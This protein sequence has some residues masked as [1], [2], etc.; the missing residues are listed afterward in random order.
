MYRKPTHIVCY[1]KSNSYNPKSI[2][3]TVFNN[4]VDRL[5]GTPSKQTEYTEEYKH[6]L[7]TAEINVSDK[8]IIRQDE[9]H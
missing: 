1:I 4:L 6:V 7:N 8:K 5:L 3:H 9:A 2:H